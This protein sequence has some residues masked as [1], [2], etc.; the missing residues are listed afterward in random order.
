[1]S[2]HWGLGRHV[3]SLNREQVVN[4]TKFFVLCEGWAIASTASGRISF[5]VYLLQF[6]LFQRTRR[7]LLYFF[8]GSQAF[9]NTLTI[10][11]IYAQCGAYPEALWDRSINATCWSHIVQRDFGYFQCSESPQTAVCIPANKH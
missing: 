2:V 7:F 8:I 6:I 4:T 9:V 3:R 1:M 11:L 5:A 10:V